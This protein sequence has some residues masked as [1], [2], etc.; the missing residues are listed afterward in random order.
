MRKVI[1]ASRRTDLTASFPEWLADALR[2]RSARVVGPRRRVIQVDLQPD[3]VH[4]LVLWSKDYS[5]LIENRHGLRD[6]ISKYS[7]IYLHFTITGL[8]GSFIEKG[9]PSPESA[10]GQMKELI[11]ITG[12]PERLSLRFDPILFW[13]EGGD[14]RSNLSFFDRLAPE[15]QA[16]DVTRVR[17]SFAQ[18]YGKAGRRAERH[19]LQFVDP[20]VGEKRAI[21]S[22]L[23]ET[24]SRRG[25][26][27]F[28]C[29]QRF[30][31]GIPGIHPSSC[32]DGALLQRLHPR[33]EPVSLIKD[34]SQRRECLCTKSVDIGSY[35][36]ACPHSCLY[37]YANPRV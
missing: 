31:D 15:L 11:D 8:G 5:A 4:T 9:V 13:K 34:R 36:Q 16:H 17:I 2:K 6:L 26:S 33:G 1:S 12:S 23:V 28:A 25:L 27:L 14:T 29:S 21:T 3:S 7:Q 10:L 19:G 37:C 24:A 22:R 30:L 18:W 35:T 20:G 32:I